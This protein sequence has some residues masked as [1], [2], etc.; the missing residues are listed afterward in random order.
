[1]IKYRSEEYKD[2]AAIFETNQLSFPEDNEARLVDM[3]RDSESYVNGLS[4]VAEKDGEVV[5]HILF[6]KLTIESSEGDFVALSLAPLAVKPNFQGQ[7]IGS[8]LIKEGIK[9]CKSLGYKAIVVV[10]HPEYYPRFGFSPARE[11]G[12]ELPFPVPDEA[13]MVYEIVPGYLD[14]IH[15]MVKLPPEFDEFI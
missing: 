12:L 10:G 11:K 15:G 7:G 8:G 1:M 5:G 13:F 14:N 3:L 6:T 9:K 2:H 4:I